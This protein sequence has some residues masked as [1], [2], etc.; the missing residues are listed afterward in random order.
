MARAEKDD[1]FTIPKRVQAAGVSTLLK[2][3]PQSVIVSI[4]TMSWRLFAAFVDA[5]AF[6]RKRH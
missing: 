1:T 4:K 6:E 2:P 5:K 3:G